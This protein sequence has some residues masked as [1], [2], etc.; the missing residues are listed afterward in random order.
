MTA[1]LH[2]G[3]NMDFDLCDTKSLIAMSGLLCL[4]VY[5][6]RANINANDNEES[7]VAKL[8]ELFAQPVAA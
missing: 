1:N 7:T 2:M 3:M 5:P 4:P 6:P 8:R